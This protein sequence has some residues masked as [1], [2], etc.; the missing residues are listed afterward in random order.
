VIIVNGN[1]NSV[2][3]KNQTVQNVEVIE[4]ML[5]IVT[6]HMDISKHSDNFVVLVKLNVLNVLK[7]HTTVLNVLKIESINQFAAVLM[8][9]IIME[10]QSV[11]FVL[12]N[13]KH[14]LMLLIIVSHVQ[15][16]LFNLHSV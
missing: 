11:H 4:L 8:V 12:N 5:L 1:V 10:E 15:V 9:G 3:M 16:I 14:V 6:V 7:P 2:N 13:V